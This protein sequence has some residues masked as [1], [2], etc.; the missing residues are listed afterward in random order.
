ME[1]EEFYKN[2]EFE[3]RV[4]KTKGMEHSQQVFTGTSKLVLMT[5]IASLLQ[6]CLDS[7]VMTTDELIEIVNMVMKARKKGIR[8]NVIYNSFEEG[9]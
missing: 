4:Y 7:N 1:T 2:S 6:S 5:G 9:E 3:I 8:N